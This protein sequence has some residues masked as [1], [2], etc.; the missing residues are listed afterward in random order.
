MKVILA[1]EVSEPINESR[2]ERGLP[3]L[4][5]LYMRDVHQE[6]NYVHIVDKKDEAMIFETV[7]EL[8]QYMKDVYPTGLIEKIIIEG[9]D[10][11]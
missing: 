3:A 4:E 5:L 1:Y 2:I 6:T 7:E 10:D 11:E 9:G 8:K